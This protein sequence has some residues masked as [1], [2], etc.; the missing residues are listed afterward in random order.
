MGERRIRLPDAAEPILKAAVEASKYGLRL[1]CWCP[2]PDGFGL[3]P[4][5]LTI[6]MLMFG[7]ISVG[8]CSIMSGLTISTE[9]AATMNV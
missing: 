1:V 8:I 7:T 5:E 2:R 9:S 3:L 6:E 4:H